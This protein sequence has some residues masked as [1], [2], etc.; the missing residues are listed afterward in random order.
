M[1][2]QEIISRFINNGDTI[3]ANGL[4]V[5]DC[6]II[7]SENKDHRINNSDRK[8]IRENFKTIEDD[9]EILFL[10]DLTFWSTRCQGCVITDRAL[11]FMIEKDN[12]SKAFSLKWGDIASVKIDAQKFCISM[13]D[14]SKHCIDANLLLKKNNPSEKMLNR[15][16]DFLNEVIELEHPTAKKDNIVPEVEI[17]SDDN[18]STAVSIVSTTRRDKN[19][20]ETMGCSQETIDFIKVAMADG[21]IDDKDFQILQLKI[22]E[23]GV[24]STEFNYML[25]KATEEYQKSAKSVIKQL[26]SA[27]ELAEKMAQ[28]EKQPNEQELNETLPTL[29]S[30]VAK[31]TDINPYVMLSAMTLETIGKAIGRFV[32]EPSKLNRFKADIIRVIDIPLFPEV[33]MD[34]CS[35]AQSQ[36][37]QEQQ[38]IDS[39]GLFT[40]LSD[41]LFGN[42]V[43]LVPIWKEKIKHVLDKATTRYG[44]NPEI[45]TLFAK[46]RD[47]PLKRL[48]T[49]T[50]C[51]EIMMFPTPP[52]VSDFV[53][54]L[55]YSFIK[56]QEEG[57]SLR[58]AYYK[59]YNRLYKDGMRLSEQY[60]CL[61]KILDEYRVKPIYELISNS[62]NQDYIAM[63]NAPERID[64]LLEVL[65]YLKSRPDLKQLHKRIYKQALKMYD[66]DDTA[67]SEIKSFKP[68]NIF[69]I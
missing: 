14:G 31:T 59:L 34:F 13:Y 35:Y 55:Q 7:D 11:H 22:N 54:I 43:N 8:E 66:S 57:N 63:F 36:L 39:K 30:I 29:N 1:S 49:L 2:N 18:N 27:F 26:S 24:N 38:K 69:G 52:Y 67:I 44:N 6:I 62:S 45:M 15:I 4:N 50:N 25:T 3:W 37:I 12:P 61:H 41:S 56:L 64:D 68:N 60:V 23:D 51:D 19:I 5:V 21:V 20:W 46:W 9:E 58:E 42:D 33:I 40:Q 48:M 53:D 47:T 28:K 32:K 17:K 65:Q 10:R 16:A